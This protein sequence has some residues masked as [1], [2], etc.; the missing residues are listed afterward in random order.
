M[1]IHLVPFLKLFQTLTRCSSG[2]GFY[3]IFQP[4]YFDANRNNFNAMDFDTF[5]FRRVVFCA[6]EMCVVF[7]ME[8][9]L[10]AVT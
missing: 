3:L 7:S 10:M 2:I 4:L 9:M 6:P 5:F 1:L 8:T